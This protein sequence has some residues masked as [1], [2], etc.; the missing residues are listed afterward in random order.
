MAPEA[1]VFF[2]RL[3]SMI[4]EKRGESDSN[5]MGWL[6]CVIGFCLLRSKGTRSEN[7]PWKW[8]RA[9]DHG[10]PSSYIMT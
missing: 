9:H 6:R 10:W 7:R 3:A 2:K 1:K 8:I 4:A 5:T